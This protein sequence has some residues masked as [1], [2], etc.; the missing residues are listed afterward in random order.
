MVAGNI[1]DKVLS[2]IFFMCVTELYFLWTREDEAILEIEMS[3]RVWT[4]EFANHFSH[5]HT[6]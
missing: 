2:N 3:V 1:T 5:N 4:A 6:N